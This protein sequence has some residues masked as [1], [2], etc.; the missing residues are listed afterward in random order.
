MK[1]ISLISIILISF[2][3]L[4]QNI[5]KIQQID[6]LLINKRLGKAL[7]LLEIENFDSISV[8]SEPPGF[9]RG[10]WGNFDN[11]HF[12]LI[13]NKTSSR[14]IKKKYRE[15]KSRYLRRIKRYKVIGVSWTNGNQ[16]NNVGETIGHYAYNRFGGC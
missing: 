8:I 4:N 15:P 16:C 10:V 7:K 13:I 12:Q 11:Y 9:Y 2:V 1:H 5:E 3:G 14:R 6:S